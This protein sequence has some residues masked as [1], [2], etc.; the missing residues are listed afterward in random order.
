MKTR[1]YYDTRKPYNPKH[2]YIYT[3]EGGGEYICQ[4]WANQGGVAI[5]Q[6]TRSGWCFV[7]HGV[8]IYE[9]GQIDWDYSTG[10]SFAKVDLT[11]A[12]RYTLAMEVML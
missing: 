12:T 9:D 3:N 1:A 2:G 7:A 8:G 11:N 5:M 6:N 10:G 4:S